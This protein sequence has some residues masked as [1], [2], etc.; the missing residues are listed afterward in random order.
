M[1]LITYHIHFGVRFLESHDHMHKNIHLCC[2]TCLSFLFVVV[3]S[4]SQSCSTLCNPM[5]CCMPGF[6]IRHHPPE[7]TQLM[8]IELVMPSNHLIS[9]RP[10]LFLPSIFP[11]IRVFSNELVLHIRLPKYRS[12]SISPSNEYSG[13]IF[14]MTDRFDLLAVQ[15]TLKS[16]L[17]HHTFL[18]LF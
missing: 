12:F 16:L 6:P 1:F 10:L 17:Q 11:S 3:Q 7:F 5:N 9:C 4:L 15:G 2:L 8:S 13:L 14:F 18:C